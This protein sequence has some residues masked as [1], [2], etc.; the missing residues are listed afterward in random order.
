MRAAR[1]L[2]RPRSAQPTRTIHTALSVEPQGGAGAA[3]DA[4]K[5]MAPL[6]RAILTV[7]HFS[8]EG[9]LARIT[10]ESA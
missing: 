5:A 1:T 8:V 9:Y 2:Q 6:C 7:G 10:L 3:P 4:P